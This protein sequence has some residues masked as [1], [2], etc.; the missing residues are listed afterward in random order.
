MCQGGLVREGLFSEEKSREKVEDGG[1]LRPEGEEGRG[2]D[3]DIKR[4]KK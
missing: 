3:R 2:C 1:K 4:I